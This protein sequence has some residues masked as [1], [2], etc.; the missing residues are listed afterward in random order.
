MLWFP[1]SCPQGRGLKG[2]RAHFSQVLLCYFGERARQSP[3]HKPGTS[4]PESVLNLHLSFCLLLRLS[5]DIA[6]LCA[7][8][9]GLCSRWWFEASQ[10]DFSLLP[11][12][13][14]QILLGVWSSLELAESAVYSHLTCGWPDAPFYFWR[15][16]HRAL[17]RQLP[18][19]VLWARK[20][21]SSA[22][23][24]TTFRVGSHA[25]RGLSLPWVLPNSLD[26]G[27]LGF[28]PG[29]HRR[30]GFSCRL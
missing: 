27:H 11:T 16:G 21:C 13:T 19:F 2:A 23:A 29:A 18:E 10:P 28:S 6:S 20:P 25:Q 22:A 1:P 4:P 8:C 15:K 9:A 12:P 26:S 3:R 5:G 17:L 24:V 14:P 7:C 30:S